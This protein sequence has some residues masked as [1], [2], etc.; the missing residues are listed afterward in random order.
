MEQGCSYLTLSHTPP[1]A[2][3]DIGSTGNYVYD[4]V[5]LTRNLAC[6]TGNWR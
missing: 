1:H 6:G 2:D 4:E 3:T 5:Y